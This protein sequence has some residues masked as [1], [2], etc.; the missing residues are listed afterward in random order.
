MIH[1]LIISS[2]ATTTTT[3]VASIRSLVQ[4]SAKL[5]RSFLLTGHSDRDNLFNS[6]SASTKA[7]CHCYAQTTEVNCRRTFAAQHRAIVDGSDGNIL[8]MLLTVVVSMVGV[9]ASTLSRQCCQ[10]QQARAAPA[11]I[12]W[13]LCVGLSVRQS[14]YFASAARPHRPIRGKTCQEQTQINGKLPSKCPSVYPQTRHGRA[15]QTHRQTHKQRREQQP[16]PLF[17]FRR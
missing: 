9:S 17:F 12:R 14:R 13:L 7:D 8:F 3:T 6:S 10:E 5:A 11:T 2:V 4:A 16:K 1:Q 15:V